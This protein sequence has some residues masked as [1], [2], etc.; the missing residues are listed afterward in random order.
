MNTASK[1]FGYSEPASG[2]V[3]VMVVMVGWRMLKKDCTL[4]GCRLH[5]SRRKKWRWILTAN[6]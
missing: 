5:G 1:E 2:P 4:V 6:S 3:L